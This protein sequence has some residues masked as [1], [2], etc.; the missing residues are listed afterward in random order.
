M[1]GTTSALRLIFSKGLG[2]D[3]DDEWVQPSN[4]RSFHIFDGFALVNRL[5][6]SASPPKSSQGRPTPTMLA[7]CLEHFEATLEILQPTLIVLQGG[8]VAESVTAALPATRRRSDYLYETEFSGGRALV[9]AFSHPSAQGALRWGDTLSS[10]Y[11]GQVV[12][13]TLRRALRLL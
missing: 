3:W 8:L 7:N 4:G 12:A 6:C 1:R 13:P 11:L 5:L 9:C 2:A 10:P